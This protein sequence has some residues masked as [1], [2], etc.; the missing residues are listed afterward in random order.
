MVFS[1][2]QFV[3]FPPPCWSHQSTAKSRLTRSDG[4]PGPDSETDPDDAPGGDPDPARTTEGRRST[5]RPR[6]HPRSVS[7]PSA[8]PKFPPHFPSW[9]PDGQ[10]AAAVSDS[11]DVCLCLAPLVNT[12]PFLLPPTVPHLVPWYRVILYLLPQN[13]FWATFFFLH[14]GCGGGRA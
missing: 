9:P 8:P 6:P 1:H 4:A 7:I 14:G 2:P 11:V 12:N 5:Q 10:I 13:L 3:T